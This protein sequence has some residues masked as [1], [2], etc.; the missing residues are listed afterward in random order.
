M[1]SYIYGTISITKYAVYTNAVK[2]TKHTT[3]ATTQSGATMRQ[4]DTIPNN[5]QPPTTFLV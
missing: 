1:L 3:R 2:N 5:T 4:H